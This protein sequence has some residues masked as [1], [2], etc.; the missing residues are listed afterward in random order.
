MITYEDRANKFLVN[1]KAYDDK[2]LWAIVRSTNC[3]T[4]L[5]CRIVTEAKKELRN[6]GYDVI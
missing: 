5:N 4:E 1:S 2:E 3:H 6:R